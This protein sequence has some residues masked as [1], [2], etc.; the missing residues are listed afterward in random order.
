MLP[1]RDRLFRND[2]EIAADG[3]RQLRFTDVTEA[4]GLDATGYGMGVATGDFDKDGWTDL[5]VTNLGSNQLFRNN[6]DSTFSDV[7][8]RAGVDDPRWSTS[9]AFVDLDGDGWL[10]LYVANYVDF[11]VAGRQHCQSLTGAADYCGPLAYRSL[12]DRLFRNRGDGTFDDLIWSAEI[13]QRPGAGLGVVSGDFDIDGR[14]DLYVA[15]DGMPNFL[16]VLGTD[17]KLRETAMATGGALNRE[18]QAEAGMGVTAADFDS[19]GDEDLLV[20]HLALESNTLYRNLGDGV[21]EDHSVAT[22]IGSASWATT[23][24]GTAWLDFDNDGWLDLITVAGAVLIIPE[25]QAE[26]DPYPLSMPNQLFHNTGGGHFEEVS[27]R[28]GA[29]FQISEVSRGVATGDL[30]NDGDTDVVLSN[31]SGP[32]RLLMNQVGSAGNWVGIRL[33][34]DADDRDAPGSWVAVER[35]GQP[36]SWQRAQTNGSYLSASDPRLL[37]GLGSSPDVARV[38]VRWPDG[39]Q[40]AFEAAANQYQTLRQGTGRRVDEPN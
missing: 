17:G 35:P 34:G 6:G 3:T 31:N 30:D 4:S 32:A 24:F 36:T 15:N 22:G 8:R 28:A 13:T 12:T 37:F 9:A 5:Y 11:S 2:L 39:M 33:I 38:L 19:D 29:S 25:L 7:T 40:E 18:G 10:D 26:G 16:W 14:L 20:T 21:F 27:S 23:S 1:L